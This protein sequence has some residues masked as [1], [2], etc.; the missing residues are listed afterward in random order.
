MTMNV[1]DIASCQECGL[2]Y[3]LFQ[4]GMSGVPEWFTKVVISIY[5]LLVFRCDFVE[6]FPVMSE[7]V[8]SVVAQYDKWITL[9]YIFVFYVKWCLFAPCCLVAAHLRCCLSLRRWPCVVKE[10]RCE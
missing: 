5:G 2:S 10:W 8:T 7:S 3:M 4:R 9:D 1:H 6:C